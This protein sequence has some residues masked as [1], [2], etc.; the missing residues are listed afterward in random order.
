MNFYNKE[1]KD[2]LV[3]IKNNHELWIT[4][5]NPEQM[6][7]ITTDMINSLVE[8]LTYADFDHNIKVGV[9]T[10]AGKAFCAGGDIKAM[11][12]KS[13]MFA[14][15]SNELRMRYEHGIQRIPETIEKINLPLIALVN[16]PAIG[17]GCDLSMM[18]DLRIGSN[19]A[20][21]AET[22]AR[23]GLVPG[24]GGTFF[25]QRVVGYSKAMEMFLTSKSFSGKESYDFGL[26]NIF[27]DQDTELQH[28]TEELCKQISLNAP[29]A[30]RLTK[31]AMKNSY[32]NDLRTSLNMLSSFQ[33]I[34]QRTSD[35][36]EALEAFENKRD[37]NFSGK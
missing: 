15:D 19:K 28:S 9:I 7:A 35:H 23:M 26:L 11:K 2:L 22:F 5:N 17:A 24:D 14:G 10:G 33:G 6:N 37:P 8:V 21:F 3:E 25:L 13:G 34:A 27:V 36:F 18:C 29:I 4:L 16:G 30:L 32:L 31:M 12:N 1:F 20:R